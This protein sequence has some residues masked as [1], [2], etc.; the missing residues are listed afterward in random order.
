[1]AFD[2][3]HALSVS[4]QLSSRNADLTAL[5]H[6]LANCQNQLRASWSGPDQQQIDFAITKLID[7]I[8]R[9]QRQ[10]DLTCANMNRGAGALKTKED[11]ERLAAQA[12]AIAG[13]GGGGGGGG[14]W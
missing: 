14:G 12:R 1:M 4:R 6:S 13:G 9:A 3:S 2:L 10:I 5:R 8:A 11:T 7:K